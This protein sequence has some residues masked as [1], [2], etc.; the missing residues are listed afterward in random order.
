MHG[1]QNMKTSTFYETSNLVLHSKEPGPEPSINDV[2]KAHE[3]SPCVSLRYPLILSTNMLLNFQRDIF[4][5]SVQ[6]SIVS[7]YDVGEI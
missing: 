7:N 6:I 2:N 4:F 3:F 5:F 1:Q